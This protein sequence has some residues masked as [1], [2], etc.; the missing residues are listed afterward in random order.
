[1]FL[2]DDDLCSLHK[3]HGHAFLPAPCQAFPFGFFEDEQGRSQALASRYCPSI[4]DNYGQPLT[5]KLLRQK[6]E[7]A[8]RAAPMSEKMGLRSGRVLPRQQYAK[9]VDVWRQQLEDCPEPGTT[10]A[11]MFDFTQ[12]LDSLLPPDKNPSNP[13]FQELLTQARQGEFPQLLPRPLG[14]SGRVFLS[15]LLGSITWP[16]SAMLAH[17][18]EPIG[19]WEKLRSW[20]S[21]LCWLMRWG[22]VRLLFVD[23]PIRIAQIAR[24]APFLHAEA[25]RPVA[26]FLSEVLRRRQNMTRQTYLHRV[27][28]DLALM[29]TLI[30][31]YARAAAASEGLQVVGA[32][33]VSQGISMAELLFTHQGESSQG[34]VLQQLRLRLMSDPDDFRRLLAAEI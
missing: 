28:V 15:H 18:L 21:S 22:R 32:G 6:L 25:G 13:E 16:T 1:V 34:Y 7:L 17:R 11:W 31:Q 4:R 8:G 33:H 9:L 3:R 2:D 26:R 19:T 30:S 24:V 27:I 10:L 14:F 5:Q 20:W 23:K 12:Q 29:A